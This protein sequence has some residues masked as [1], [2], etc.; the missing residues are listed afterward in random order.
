MTKDG[1]CWPKV[2]AYDQWHE[3]MLGQLAHYRSIFSSIKMEMECTKVIQHVG[4]GI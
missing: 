2:L 1:L 4:V 3:R